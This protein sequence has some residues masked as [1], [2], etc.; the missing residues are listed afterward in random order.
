M[1]ALTPGPYEEEGGGRGSRG[2]GAEP[3]HPGGR[4]RGLCTGIP[5]CAPCTPGSDGVVGA[6][7][8][9]PPGAEIAEGAGSARPGHAIIAP[10]LEKIEADS[11][12]I[13]GSSTMMPNDL[14]Q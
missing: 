10:I 2:G 9:S 12:G 4:S 1:S 13:G 8:A 5:T 11:T 3:W 7:L 14:R 6:G